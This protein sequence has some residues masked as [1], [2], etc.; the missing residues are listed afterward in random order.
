MSQVKEL[1][2]QQTRYSP[3]KLDEIVLY[4]NEDKEVLHIVYRDNGKVTLK[5]VEIGKRYDIYS[6][7]GV[8]YDEMKENNNIL[9]SLETGWK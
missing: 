2:I 4:R 5:R 7:E 9:G 1:K 6:T 8:L 3:G